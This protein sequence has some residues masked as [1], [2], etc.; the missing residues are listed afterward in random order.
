MIVDK[1]NVDP[2]GMYDIGD[3]GLL[4]SSHFVLHT[5]QNLHSIAHLM[6]L[7]TS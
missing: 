7:T 4:S 3:W 5:V 6:L 2:V 1:D